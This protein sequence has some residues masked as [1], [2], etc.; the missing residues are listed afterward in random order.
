M[1]VTTRADNQYHLENGFQVLL[2]DHS[3]TVK[4]DNAIESH[5]VLIKVCEYVL[6]W[7]V[8]YHPIIIIIIS[9]ARHWLTLRLLCPRQVPDHVIVQCFASRNANIWNVRFHLR[10]L[11]WKCKF[12][13]MQLKMITV[14]VVCCNFLL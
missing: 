5:R 3:Y 11:Q 10:Q 1:A 13:E 9:R 14:D 4:Y 2:V 12:T 8:V 6:F 7:F